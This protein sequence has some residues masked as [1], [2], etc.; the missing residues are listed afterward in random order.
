MDLQ[1]G[2]DDHVHLDYSIVKEEYK[3]QEPPPIHKD[4]QQPDLKT[5]T[6]KKQNKTERPR[7]SIC[8]VCSKG[9]ISPALLRYH[10]VV[11]TKERPCKCPHCPK[12][13]GNQKRLMKHMQIHKERQKHPCSQCGKLLMS[14]DSLVRHIKLHV[15]TRKFECAQCGQGFKDKPC[16]KQ[17]LFQIH[18]KNKLHVI[19]APKYP[20][21]DCGKIFWDR[22]AL[23][24]HSITHTDIR[25]VECPI[26]LRMF[27]HKQHLKNHMLTHSE[28]KPFVCEVCNRSF[29]KL[30]ELQRHRK[31]TSLA[32]NY[33][34]KKYRS[35]GGLEQHLHV[36][37]RG[38]PRK[39]KG[40]P[41][42]CTICK[43]TFNTPEKLKQHVRKHPVE[44]PF[45]CAHCGKNFPDRRR[46]RSHITVVHKSS[47]KRKGTV[48]KC[49]DCNKEFRGKNLF[50]SHRVIHSKEISYEC[51]VCRRKFK[52]WDYLQKHIRIHREDRPLF[53]CKICGIKLRSAKNLQK[54]EQRHEN[55]SVRQACDKASQ[56]EG[57]KEDQ[58]KG[59]E[60]DQNNKSLNDTSKDQEDQEKLQLIPFQIKTEDDSADDLHLTELTTEFECSETIKI[61][62]DL[63]FVIKTEFDSILIS[64]LGYVSKEVILRINQFLC[65]KIMDFDEKIPIKTE[66]KIEKEDPENLFVDSV[67]KE[68]YIIQEDEIPDDKVKQEPIPGNS[69][70]KQEVVQFVIQDVSEGYVGNEE[71]VGR[72]KAFQCPICGKKFLQINHLKSHSRMHVDGSIG[73]TRTCSIC[74]KFYRNKYNFRKHYENHMKE[75]KPPDPDKPR[76]VRRRRKEKPKPTCEQCGRVFAKKSRLV[77]HLASRAHD[78]FYRCRLCGAPYKDRTALRMHHQEEHRKFFECAECGKEFEKKVCLRNHLW[79]FHF[80]NK[81]PD[82]LKKKEVSCELCGKIFTRT[83]YLRYHLKIIHGDHKEAPCPHCPKTLKNE[84]QLRS[85]I[86]RQHKP[87]KQIHK[88]N[89]CSATFSIKTAYMRHLMTHIKEPVNCYYCRSVL[90][91]RARLRRHIVAKHKGLPWDIKDGPISCPKCQES[92]ENLTAFNQHFL[93]THPS[94]EP[95]IVECSICQKQYTRKG[96][97]V[98]HM[99]RHTG[100][101]LNADE[102]SAAENSL[103]DKE[104]NPGNNL[105]DP[106]DIKTEETEVTDGAEDPLQFN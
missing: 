95:E 70:V 1:D 52:T 10:M 23:K 32:C 90:K 28:E 76:R 4:D 65:S 58:T 78:M 96:N 18:Y 14:R 66:I 57:K 43:K 27:K 84:I 3:I 41:I 80:V 82:Y 101:Q 77:R 17:H 31:G 71:K 56:K 100:R 103:S 44:T 105:I 64:K 106:C 75:P 67:V 19:E 16:L 46:I 69:Q 59:K 2:A 36:T 35:P 55:D 97:L 39:W 5:E 24:R 20:C 15:A 104:E 38:F 91:N 53:P 47:N 49:P 29:R 72:R 63:K 7:K 26:C 9:F 6:Q 54:H 68:E 45:E 8:S 60:K 33:C 99:L 87:E 98:K 21:K 88:C 25:N 37:H 51:E 94:D 81:I 86:E 92:L 83:D 50:A 22:S 62:S 42:S 89:T 30:Q 48:F 12:A 93:E 61:E 73:H 13:F 79:R 102:E 34:S 11:H 74:G 85:H 40:G